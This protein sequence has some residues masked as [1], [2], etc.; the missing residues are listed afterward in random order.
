[1]KGLLKSTL[2][3]ASKNSTQ[4]LTVSSIL[5]VVATT[6]LAVKATP[7]ALSIIEENEPE[8]ALDIVR[9]TWKCYIPTVVVGGLTISSII[10][11]QSISIKRT[12]AIASAYTL[13]ETRFKDY[14]KKFVEKVGEK[15]VREVEDSIAKDKVKVV[16]EGDII[17][18][19]KGDTLCF[20]ACSGRYF[21]GNIEDIKRALNS[22][23]RDMLSDHFISLN[24]IYESIGLEETTLGR[25]M[26]WHIDDGL[27]E[28]RFSAILS[29]NDTPCLV[30]DFYL[31]P[32]YLD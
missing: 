15:K 24:D 4:V 26:G 1:M 13:S 7:K 11:N 23:S 9:D 6:V 3:F 12:A 8:T 32:R 18:T 19:G 20:D 29:P 28:P 25:N 31:E 14:R 16:K 5:G 17:K 22:L 30:L 10:W 21:Y 2:D 27:I